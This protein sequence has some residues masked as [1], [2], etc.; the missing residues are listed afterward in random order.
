MG[1]TPSATLKIP[2]ILKISDNSPLPH[3][4]VP[5]IHCITA[6]NNEKITQESDITKLAIKT[7][8]EIEFTDI[9]TL[10]A[11]RFTFSTKLHVSVKI[12]T[13]VLLNIKVIDSQLPQLKKNDYLLGIENKYFFN[14][15]DLFYFVAMSD[16]QLLPFVVRR[17]NKVGVVD[18]LINDGKIGVEVE[19]GIIC[20]MDNEECVYCSKEEFNKESSAVEDGESKK[21]L[22]AEPE[23]IHSLPNDKF[24]ENTNDVVKQNTSEPVNKDGNDVDENKP[25]IEAVESRLNGEGVCIFNENGCDSGETNKIKDD[26][27]EKNNLRSASFELNSENKKECEDSIEFNK[28]EESI[29]A[30]DVTFNSIARSYAEDG[31]SVVTLNTNNYF[32]KN[33]GDEHF[34]DKLEKVSVNNNGKSGIV[35]EK[36]ENKVFGHGESIVGDCEGDKGGE[37]FN[38]SLNVGCVDTLYCKTVNSLNNETEKLETLLSGKEVDNGS[39][40]EHSKQIFNTTMLGGDVINKNEDHIKNNDEINVSNNNDDGTTVDTIENNNTVWNWCKTDT[41]GVDIKS[42]PVLIG[43]EITC[44]LLNTEMGV[45]VGVVGVNCEELPQPKKEDRE[46]LLKLFTEFEDNNEFE[47]VKKS[48]D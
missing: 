4:I 7:A 27:V 29:G 23:N 37:L 22:K 12:V 32:N 34:V 13:P 43:N 2:C 35:G 3:T 16:K 1:N 36:V 5:F 40:V 19:E 14:E 17:G 47:T 18:V 26:E 25:G 44:G 45:S 8:T 41:T 10:V 21:N 31:N 6:V 11:T 38:Q 30:K 20:R 24:N 46:A 42:K 39:N 9:R 48:H 33:T 15:D 28:S